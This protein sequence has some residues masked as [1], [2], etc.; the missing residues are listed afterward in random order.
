VRALA[1]L[2][3]APVTLPPES[4]V[5]KQVNDTLQALSSAG[6]VV[7]LISSHEVREAMNRHFAYG[8]ALQ[9]KA[10]K[11]EEFGLLPFNDTEVKLHE[12]MRAEL[13]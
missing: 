12:A 6:N 9:R 7:R 11:R 13:N 8:Q 1:E 3:R 5:R 4:D 2:S 10:M